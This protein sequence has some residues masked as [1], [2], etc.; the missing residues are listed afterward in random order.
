MGNQKRRH[1]GPAAATSGTPI[2]SPRANGVVSSV[3]GNTQVA[4][5]GKKQHLPS[6][7]YQLY[8]LRPDRNSNTQLQIEAFKQNIKTVSN[9]LPGVIPT[10]LDMSSF[11]PDGSPHYIPP[12][13]GTLTSFVN[14]I[15]STKH[16]CIVGVTNLPPPE[17]KGYLSAMTIE[18]QS[19][20]LPILTNTSAQETKTSSTISS[21]PPARKKRGGVAPLL[22]PRRPVTNNNTTDP[23]QTAETV[24]EKETDKD[25]TTQNVESYPSTKVYKGS[26]RSGQL[27][28]SDYPNQSLVIIGS[29]N[30]GGEVWSE[31]DVFVFG[32]LR[33][34]VLAGLR[35][36]DSADRHKIDTEPTTQVPPSAK[37]KAQVFATSFDPE[38]I[39][40][41]DTFT[42]IEDVSKL[43]LDGGGPA[44]AFLDEVTGELT[45]EMFHL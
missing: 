28:T 5:D 26:I 23:S 38:L 10:V 24:L 29:V 14:E 22:R 32:K 31:G 30:P 12:P 39:C 40:I 9:T 37:G 20:N 4:N 16:I 35:N 11:H 7:S 1:I 42:T 15:Q 45:F 18:A 36:V 8:N 2:I 27:V 43:G 3:N 17:R 25:A 19:M 13:H 34:R 33:G 6:S 44:V 21:Q 41:G